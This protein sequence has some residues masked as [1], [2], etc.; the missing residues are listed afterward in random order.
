MLICNILS[1]ALLI[2]AEN[3]PPSETRGTRNES[4]RYSDRNI[5]KG[6][7]DKTV[8]SLLY[9]KY[10]SVFSKHFFTLFFIAIATQ[11]PLFVRHGDHE[12]KEWKM[13]INCIWP[14]LT[15]DKIDQMW[16]HCTIAKFQW[17]VRHSEFWT[18]PLILSASKYFR[19]I[20]LS[21][22]PHPNISDKFLCH[23]IF[24]EDKMNNRPYP[25]YTASLW[26]TFTQ[27]F[28]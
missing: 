28:Y 27:I 22:Y 18:L 13:K 25:R 17:E 20:S 9:W 14:R 8:V 15:L 24:V 5:V 23:F 12:G 4:E 1:K 3:S 11:L 7:D 26:K 6:W 10:L 2:S 19:L 16:K 21:L